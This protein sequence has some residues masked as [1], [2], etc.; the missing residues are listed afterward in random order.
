MRG[1]CRRR[2]FVRS[3]RLRRWAAAL[4]VN[5]TGGR[6]FFLRHEPASF[7][8][9]CNRRSGGPGHAAGGETR[10]GELRSALIGA[11]SVKRLAHGSKVS[12]SSRRQ[13]SSAG[14]TNVRTS[15]SH[16][17]LK[18]RRVSTSKHGHGEHHADATI[19][20]RGGRG[21]KAAQR[22]SYVGLHAA[23]VICAAVQPAGRRP[24]PL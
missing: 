5:Q 17:L 2:Q 6:E 11:V 24:G 8:K 14:S 3:A 12:V 22:V 4:T 15:G 23:N 20:L 19:I 9:A 1:R 18:E 10:H 7:G 21:V 13:N 16:A